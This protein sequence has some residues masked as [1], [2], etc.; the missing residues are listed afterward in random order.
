VVVDALPWKEGAALESRVFEGIRRRMIFDHCKW[1]PQVEDVSVL[2]PAPLVLRSRAWDQLCRWSE[3]L[4][5]ECIAAETELLARPG[6]RRRLR[7]P[8]VLDNAFGDAAQPLDAA[9]RVM[10]F[11]FHYT[12]QGWRISE[13]NADVPGGFIEASA[14]TQ[15]ISQQA[16]GSRPSGDPS[17]A[18]ARALLAR[19]GRDATVAMVHA[20]AYADDAQVMEYLSKRLEDTGLRP[21]RTAPDD[22]RVFDCVGVLRFFPA[23]WLP[24]LP[25]TA[26][27][28][29]YFSGGMPP[30]CNPASAL[31]TQCKS[32]SFAWSELRTPLPLWRSLLP[33]TLPCPA[34]GRVDLEAWI[35]K[36][37]LGR[38]GDSIGMR[39]VTTDEVWKALGRALRFGGKRAFVMQRRF[40]AVAWDSPVGPLYPCIGMFVV[41]GK[42]CGAYGRAARLPLVDH[43]AYDVAILVS[44]EAESEQLAFAAGGHYKTDER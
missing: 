37:A 28:R 8:A 22:P 43:R 16:G 34:L 38:V 39:G 20:T 23:E 44:Q 5:R 42:A 15:L 25:Q 26:G 18:L 9:A 7:L 41:D 4:Y 36:P 14:F 30:Q 40:E 29:R 27:W 35:V 31:L 11:D 19:L 21:R 24:N 17:A 3:A 6:V 33:E 2:L 1:D 12:R 10:R 13:V 32:F